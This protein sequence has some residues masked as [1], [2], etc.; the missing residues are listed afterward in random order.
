VEFIT[1]LDSA[2]GRGNF[3]ALLAGNKVNTELGDNGFS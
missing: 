3:L 1:V 2:V